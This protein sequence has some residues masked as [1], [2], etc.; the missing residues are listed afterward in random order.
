MRR[1]D[2]LRFSAMALMLPLLC[3]G[4]RSAGSGVRQA[5]RPVEPSQF[6]LGEGEPGRAIPSEVV[7]PSPRP[8]R[9]V[10]RPRPTFVV[11]PGAPMNIADAAAPIET[12]VLLDAKVG[13]INGRAVFAS[14][15]LEPLE[16]NFRA[17]ALELDHDTWVRF[18]AEQIQVQLRSMITDEL[19]R[20]EALSRLSVEQKAGLRRFLQ[21]VRSNLISQS[22]GSSQRASNKLRREQGLTE[23]EYL[24][25]HEERTLVR[26]TIQEEISDRVNVS[27]RDIVRRYRRDESK[28]HPEPAARFRIVRVDADDEAAVASVKDALA[29]GTPFAEVAADEVNTWTDEDGLKVMPFTPPRSE[30]EFFGPPALNDPARTIAVGE[31]TGPIEFG[32][33]LIWLHIESVDQESVPLY[34]A[35][36]DIA[37]EIRSERVNQN[38]ERY[39]DRLLGR[40][41]VTDVNRMMLRLIA[42]ATERYG[43]EAERPGPQ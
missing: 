33:S 26:Y 29:A 35:Q 28:Y 32:S 16:G 37:A 7:T 25:Q 43:P 18:A 19:L 2:A 3:V 15:F 30:A 8:D 10:S 5:H 14:E 13:D 22:G 12:P 34:D 31:W 41:S 24:R 9:D 38:L 17:K 42:I 36:L 40:A 6:V 23:Q 1:H 21:D 4:C 11:E 27:W 20:A 39:I